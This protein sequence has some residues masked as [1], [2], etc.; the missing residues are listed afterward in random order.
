ML[1]DGVVKW[2]VAINGQGR[3]WLEL[4]QFKS[5]FSSLWLSVMVNS[6]LRVAEESSGFHVA[7]PNCGA[8]KCRYGGLSSCCGRRARAVESGS[9][10]NA[11]CPII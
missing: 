5:C 7:F 3:I 4:S 2:C 8:V 6:S 9:S 10:K 1:R 11:V